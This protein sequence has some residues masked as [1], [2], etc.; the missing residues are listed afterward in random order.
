MNNTDAEGRL[1]LAD[2]LLY[3]QEQGVHKVRGR[4]SVH[5]VHLNH[6]KWYQMTLADALLYAQE[7]GVH[8]VRGST[9]FQARFSVHESRNMMHLKRIKWGLMRTL[10]GALQHAQEQSVHKVR[11]STA[12]LARF[13]VQ[14][15]FEAHR[16][17]P[18]DPCRRVAACAGAGRVVHMVLR[19][20]I[21]V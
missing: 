7:Q 14:R 18:D 6:I 3:A 5:I 12:F 13:S 2:A 10:V 17:G 8:K 1:T 16:T 9:A 19:G 11:G 15:A 20:Y 21:E 4:V